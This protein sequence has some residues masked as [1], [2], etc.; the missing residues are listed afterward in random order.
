MAPATRRFL[1]LILLAGGLLRFFPIW[2]G[3]PYPQARPD[4]EVSIGLALKVLDG[5]LNPHFFH[6]PSLTFYVF[7][8]V[9]GA[10]R[11]GRE[12][13]GFD[14]AMTFSDHALITRGTIAL[15]GTITLFVL[16]RLGQRIAGDVVG[17]V[18]AVFLAVALLHVRES[19]FA[20]TDVLMTLLLWTSLT[21][22]VAAAGQRSGESRPTRNETILCAWA[23]LAGGLAT[24]TKYNAGA[25][26]AAMVATQV[27]WFREA[28]SSV[29]SWAKWMPALA[30]GAVFTT[31]FIAG[32]PYAVLDYPK[33][34]DDLR[35][36]FTHLSGGHIGIDLG[37]GWMYHA[38][39]SL[40][41]GA[42]FATCA[43][44]VVGLV[45]FVRGHRP[46]AVV[47]AAFAVPFYLTLGSGYT[48]F[49]RYVLPLIPLI[50][51]CAAVGVDAASRWLARHTQMGATRA[52]AVIAMVAMGPGLV[53][54]VWF[55]VLLARTDTRVI[56]GDWLTPRLLP[57]ATVHDA[58]GS[59]TQLDLWRSQIDRRAYD[60]D[61]NVF[62]D[63][64]LPEWL[65]LS[66]SPLR[67]YASTP[68][69][70]ANLARERYVE[71][72]QV[73]GRRRGQ[74][75]VY[76]R[77]DA[78]FLPFSGFQH[79]LRPGPTITIHRRADLPPLDR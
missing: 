34:I 22:L 69:G 33:F 66:S 31:S 28:P 57:A 5:E 67:Y 54:S 51:L 72:F 14:G 39:H 2:F 17:L 71:V 27:L 43:A 21:L 50:A 77:Q 11:G 18:A 4:E 3:L 20:M 42:G 73:Q 36:D 23:G 10:A 59:Y 37:R 19:H 74:L 26:V 24:S 62:V 49:F 61:R 25:V 29:W 65:I 32:T 68:P 55:D 56:A 48:V 75:G 46:A 58:G 38:T 60:R 15:C 64:G 78:F 16:F 41:Y 12:L 13:L 40:P 1:I 76:D 30:F 8:A 47:L 35:Y 6:W 45:P 79:I 70:L 7:A 63:G 53:Y 9:L 44:A 52:L